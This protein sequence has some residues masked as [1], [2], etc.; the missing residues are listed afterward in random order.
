M[1][2]VPPPESRRTKVQLA[3]PAQWFDERVLSDKHVLSDKRVMS[4]R[5]V[6]S[7][8]PVLPD[9]CGYQTNLWCHWLVKLVL[10]DNHV[11]SLARQILLSDKRVLSLARQMCAVSL[12]CMTPQTRKRT[13]CS[14]SIGK[15]TSCIGNTQ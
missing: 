8:K 1:C 9:K 12:K 14:S 13:L 6:L 7:A 4:D 3:C 15:I 10:S 11:L 5:P 2:R